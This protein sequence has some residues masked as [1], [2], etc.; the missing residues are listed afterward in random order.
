MVRQDDGMQLNLLI[1]LTVWVDHGLCL[2]IE[3]T[4]SWPCEKTSHYCCCSHHG[5]GHRLLHRL[6]VPVPYDAMRS[7]ES[8]QYDESVSRIDM[9]QKYCGPGSVE[10]RFYKS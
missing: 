5:P 8:R 7:R 10:A 2:R 4:L 9:Q 6:E 1:N 3:A